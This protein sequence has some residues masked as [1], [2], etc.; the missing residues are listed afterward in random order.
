[1]DSI[2]DDAKVAVLGMGN[3]G[4]ALATRLL[5]QG[6]SV[7]IWNRSPRDV[8]ALLELGASSLGSLESVWEMADVVISFLS[9]DDALRNVCLGPTGIL[10]RTLDR[11]LLVDMSTVSPKASEEIAAAAAEAGVGYLRAPVSGNPLVLTAGNLTLVVSGPRVVFE[12]AEGLLARVGP[13]VL[14]VGDAEQARVVKLAINAGLAVTTEM[15]AEL[16]VL[17]ERLGLDRATFLGVLGQSVLGSPFVR[18]KT[19]GLVERDYSATFTTTLLAKDLGLAGELARGAGLELPVTALVTALV[20]EAVVGYADVDFAALLPR[21]QRASG[22]EPD[23][24]PTE[25]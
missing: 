17:T 23:I 2:D 20:G 12:A 24:A 5:G 16:V 22:L 6:L 7:A 13:T 19:A 4:R 14:Y 21:L 8:S 18:Y 10:G 9:D 3:M 15:L 11:G 1:M 25:S